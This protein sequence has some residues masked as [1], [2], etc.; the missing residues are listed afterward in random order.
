M[1]RRANTKFPPMKGDAYQTPFRPVP[2]LIPHLKNVRSFAEPCIGEGKLVRHL[3]RFGLRCTF[4]GDIQ[5]GQD[6]LT[7][8]NLP[9]VKYDAIIT[10]PPWTRSVLH[11]MIERFASIAPTW[12]LFD[13]D[14]A[15][16][17]EISQYID[18]CSHIVAVGR[19]KWIDGSEHTGKDNAAWYRFHD[20][21]SGGPRFIPRPVETDRFGFPLEAMDILNRR[22]EQAA[23]DEPLMVAA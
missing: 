8:P 7:C 12:L 3:S 5:F 18:Q 17:S 2:F 21:H 4:A 11:P 1:G 14:W 13:A 9:L 10:N 22:E 16:N 23:A 20:Q 15:Y 6:A 19:I